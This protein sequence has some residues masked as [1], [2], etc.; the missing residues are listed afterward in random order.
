MR[1]VGGIMPKGSSFVI[2]V[3]HDENDG[4]GIMS[5]DLDFDT[6]HDVLHG[7]ADFV[8]AMHGRHSAAESN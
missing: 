6:L 7:G 5:K 3:V 8:C 2:L 1:A 4:M